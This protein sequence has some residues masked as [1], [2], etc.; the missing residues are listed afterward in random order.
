VLGL[1]LLALVNEAPPHDV[2]RHELLDEGG[3]ALLGQSAL[4]LLRSVSDQPD[5]QHGSSP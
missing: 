3:A 5:V 1:E 2:A 4:D